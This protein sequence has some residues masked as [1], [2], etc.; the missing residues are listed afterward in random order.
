MTSVCE[1]DTLELCV[2]EY[3]EFL[4]QLDSDALRDEASILEQCE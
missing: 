3:N 2:A 4:S 1:D